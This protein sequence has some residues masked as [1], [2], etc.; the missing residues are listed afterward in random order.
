MNVFKKVSM[1]GGSVMLI[2]LSI[3]ITSLLISFPLAD[4][5]TIIQQAIAH[6]TTIVIAGVFKVGYVIFIVGRY[7]RGL[8]I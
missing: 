5:F 4:H 6:I 8:S 2:S 3:L 1:L 7:E